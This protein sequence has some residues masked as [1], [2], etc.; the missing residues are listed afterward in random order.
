MAAPTIYR[1]SDTS[2]PTL[3]GNAGSLIAVLDACLVSGYGSKTALGWTKDFTATNKA[4]Y[5]APAGVRHY[6]DVND[7]APDVTALGRNAQVRG[8]ETMS[9]VATG[10]GPF[11]SVPQAAQCVVP[12]SSTADAVA[13]PWLLIGDDRGFYFFNTTNVANPPVLATHFWGTIWFFGEFYSF[14]TGD[15]Y[16]SI[17]AFGVQSSSSFTDTLAAANAA[18]LLGTNTLNQYTPRAYTGIGS[19]IFNTPFVNGSLISSANISTSAAGPMPFPNPVDGGLYMNVIDLVERG[20]GTTPLA[21]SSCS[22]RGRLRGLYTPNITFTSL[23]DQDT[24]S[25]TGDFAGRTFLALKTGSSTGGMV[26][27]TT[28]WDT[29]S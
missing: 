1:S 9:A 13:R 26:V 12:K 14:L 2:A 7:S 20:S 25:G 3:N 5:R 8:Y 11:P 23:V 10:T 22:F 24:F 28:A 6:L 21:A 17:L 27:E 18:G 4:T 29:S 15:A 16:R 19:S